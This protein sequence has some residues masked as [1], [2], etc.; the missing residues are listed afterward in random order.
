MT[1]AILL[2][3]DIASGEDAAANRRCWSSYNS[4]QCSTPIYL[5]HRIFYKTNFN[6]ISISGVVWSHHNFSKK[7]GVVWPCWC[8][9][10]A[11]IIIIIIIIDDYGRRR[12]P[13][14]PHLLQLVI[15]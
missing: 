5:F 2:I 12:M 13:L 9:A 11:I 4:C 6:V 3:S 10:N 15:T 7:C 1:Y 14:S 8:G